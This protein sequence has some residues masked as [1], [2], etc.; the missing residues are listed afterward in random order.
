MLVGY[1]EDD[2]NKWRSEMFSY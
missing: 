1:S 2:M